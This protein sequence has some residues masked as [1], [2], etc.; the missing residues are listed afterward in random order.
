MRYTSR[1]RHPNWSNSQRLNTLHPHSND[2]KKVIDTQYTSAL[3][4]RVFA[5]QNLRRSTSQASAASRLLHIRHVTKNPSLQLLWNLHLQTVT[6]V[7]PLE[8]AFTQTAGCRTSSSI[9]ASL[10]TIPR[11]KCICKSLVFYALRTLPSSVSC[12][13]CICHSYENCRVYTNNSHSETHYPPLTTHH[14]LP[15]PHFPIKFG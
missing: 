3:F 14:P 15:T 2:A 12:K 9:F 7:S 5:N 8:S 11:K 13:S 1:A 4:S 10:L 6:P